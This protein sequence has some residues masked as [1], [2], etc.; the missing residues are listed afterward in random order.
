VRS[1]RLAAAIAAFVITAGASAQPAEPRAVYSA[2]CAACHGDD[3][4]GR[5]TA[6]LGFERAL[7][8]FTDCDFAVREPDGDWFAIAHRGGPTRGF[9]RLMPAFGEAL[10]PDEIQAALAQIRSF[11]T[12]PRWPRGELNL[13]RALFTE[14]AYPEDE[15]VITTTLVGEGLDSISHEF[16]WE[17]RFGPLNQIELKLPITRADLGAPQGWKN[18]T[19]DLGLGVKHTMRHSLER[20]AIL[21]IGGELVLPTGDEAKGFGKGTTVLETSVMYDKLLPRDAFVQAQAILEFPNDSTLEDE[22]VA[23]VVV[24]KTWISDAPFGRTWTPMLE[25][26][27]ARDLVGGAE[28]EWDLVPQLQVSLNKRQHVLGAIGIRQPITDRGNRPTEVVFYLLWDWFDGGVLE[29]W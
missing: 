22:L 4:R 7:P 26:L 1:I 23:R 14:K 28:I 16:V 20:G 3:G 2:A 12:D 19:G 11:C 25:L 18:G 15:A 13:P 8:D 27:A 29:G 24:G 10:R 5:S 9:D 6:V 21:A 17:Q